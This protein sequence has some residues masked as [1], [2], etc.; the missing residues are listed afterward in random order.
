MMCFAA[1]VH[2][3]AQEGHTA[4]KCRLAASQTAIR[5]HAEEL[6]QAAAAEQERRRQALMSLKSKIDEVRENVGQK[7]DRFRC[8]GSRSLTVQSVWCTNL[9][10]LGIMG[11]TAYAAQSQQHAVPAY[12]QLS[13]IATCIVQA[14]AVYKCLVGRSCSTFDL[15]LVPCRQLQKQKRDQ[16]RREFEA[17]Q[18][19]GLNPYEVYRCAAACKVYATVVYGMVLLAW[20]CTLHCTPAKD[21]G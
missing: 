15:V 3:A 17:L 18:E 20:R 19:Q 2:R 9:Y 16:E 12:D 6:A 10:E 1:A 4:A 7:A 13:T 8:V 14:A 11:A 5:A 21:A